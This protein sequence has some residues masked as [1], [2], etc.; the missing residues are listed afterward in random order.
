MSHESASKT[1]RTKIEHE[2]RVKRLQ[3]HF[4]AKMPNTLPDDTAAT[5]YLLGA[6]A[7]LLAAHA[8]YI[9]LLPP[10][11]APV[12]TG[13]P[14]VWDEVICDLQEAKT[15]DDLFQNASMVDLVAVDMADRDI[16][17]RE[18]YG[19]PLQSGNGRD[20]LRDAYDEALDGAVYRRQA[21]DE[22]VRSGPV[23]TK[24]LRACLALKDDDVTSDTIEQVVRARAYW[25]AVEAVLAT[26][27]EIE[28][29]NDARKR[30]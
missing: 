30:Q 27:E 6:T 17:G 8:G 29:R 9:V 10:E 4:A 11:P 1:S 5:A 2:L 3:D 23:D 15:S 16:V 26:R 12:D 21:F 24:A 22:S 28:R 18:R 20:A 7:A 19:K 14:S 25:R 13:G